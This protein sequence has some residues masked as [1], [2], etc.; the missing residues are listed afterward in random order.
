MQTRC[1]LCAR[2]APDGNLWCQRVAC[3][4]NQ[5]MPIFERGDHIG[6]FEIKRVIEQLPNAT[7]YQ[8]DHKGALVWLKIAHLDTDADLRAQLGYA[9][10]LKDEAKRLQGVSHPMLPA[11]LPPYKGV[12]LQADPY[13]KITLDGR[14]YYYSVF[15]AVE[16]ATLRE[17]LNE[18]PQPA[19]DEVGMIAVQ[20]AEVLV[21]LREQLKLRHLALIP[22]R[23]FIRRDR[24]G[25]PR[26]LLLDL[27]LAA[28]RDQNRLPAHLAERLTRFVPIAYTA[29]ETFEGRYSA[30][31]DVYGL[32]ALLFEMLAGQ[33]PFDRF[34]TTGAL[35]RRLISDG[36]TAQL[37]RVDIAQGKLK[38]LT[39]T[40]QSGLN[41]SEDK[42]G[43]SDVSG[44]QQRLETWFGAMPTERTRR[45]TLSEEQRF[46]ILSA[47]VAIIAVA[48]V[49]G[50]AASAG[51]MQ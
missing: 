33:P 5:L 11:L 15:A 16:G 46:V 31:T 8:V 24:E 48:L 40:V 25:L 18:T 20:I 30:Q 21:Y 51:I 47:L 1:T 6:E 42:R 38:G 43:L 14:L 32:A 22:E 44:F 27:G 41:V 12:A 13:G 50:I 34:N 39:D 35:T 7:L 4:P 23:V 37:V 2:S 3:S 19:L 29:P 17:M 28:P 45:F 26:V 9:R 36:E 10:G 49:I